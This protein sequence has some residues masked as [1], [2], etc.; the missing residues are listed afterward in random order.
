M[1]KK[2][3]LRLAY[4]RYQRELKEIYKK[5]LFVNTKSPSK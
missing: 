3:Q 2:E 1:N 4:E 5:T